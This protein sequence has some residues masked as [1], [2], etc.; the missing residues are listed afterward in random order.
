MK[1]LIVGS[2][3]F[4]GG[5]FLEFLKTQREIE[6]HTLDRTKNSN[7]NVISHSW[8]DLSDLHLNEVSKVFYFAGKAH[9][10]KKT[11]NDQEYFDINVGLLQQFLDAADKQSFKGKLVFLSS[12]KAIAD[13]VGG[14]L[15]EADIPNPITAYGK[16]KLE[17]EQLLLA[18]N[19][20]DDCYILRPCMIHGKGNKGNL[21]QLFSFVK[22]GIPN[23][24]A[25]YIN[26]RSLL[27]VDNLI[28]VF[29]KVIRNELAPNIYQVSDDGLISTNEIMELIGDT[30]GKKVIKLSTPKFLVG[31]LAK[32]G[33]VLP[34]PINSDRL[35]KLTENYRVSNRKLVKALGEN[36]PISLKEGLKITIQ[37]F[38]E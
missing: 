22:K 4:V 21:N 35:Q 27:S 34:L 29:H 17:A 19:F 8:K 20:G 14:E 36:L 26:E 37:S 12:V 38:E 24:L 11:S 9:D 1:I 25:S 5:N 28:F 13:I 23:I 30:I 10:L 16:S 32:F 33:N 3:G 15:T 6:V 7:S 31:I 18:S 2:T